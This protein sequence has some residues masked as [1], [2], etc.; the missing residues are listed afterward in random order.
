MYRDGKVEEIDLNAEKLASAEIEELMPFAV[1]SEK[2]VIKKDPSSGTDDKK[3]PTKTD[4]KT[5]TSK[6]GKTAKTG[7]RSPVV[8]WCLVLAAAGTVIG[9]NVVLRKRRKIK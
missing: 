7:D 6:S 5:N 3:T 8:L 9:I 1:L 2:E 4:K